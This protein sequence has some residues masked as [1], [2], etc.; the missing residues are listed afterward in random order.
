MGRRI[1]CHQRNR[2]RR[3][4][5]HFF[6]RCHIP[7]HRLHV[8]PR[9]TIFL[10]LRHHH[11]HLHPH[12]DA[13]QLHAH[14]HALLALSQTFRKSPP[15]RQVPSFRRRLRPTHRA[16]LSLVPPLVDA[17]PL[18][19]HCRRGRD[20]DKHPRPLQEGWHRLP[21]QGRPERI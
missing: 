16:A 1:R 12:V 2:P 21:P 7:S 19:H 5:H 11:R 18:G 10:L 3:H 6:T 17:P 20:G 9:R 8:R 4:G 14:P 15:R 13:G